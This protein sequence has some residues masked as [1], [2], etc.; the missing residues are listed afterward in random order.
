MRVC[1]TNY[2]YHSLLNPEFDKVEPM[3]KDGLQPLSKFPNSDRWQQIEKHMPGFYKNLYEN[4]AQPII[5]KPYNNSG[6][7][8]TPIDFQKLPALLLYNKTRIKIPMTRLD[9]AYCVITYI[10]N[11]ERLSFALTPENLEQT[12]VIWNADLV[13][14]WF[15][16]DKTKMF[17]YVPQ[18][19]IYQPQGIPI[20]FDDI[21]EFSK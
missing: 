20:E 2:V 16:K 3:L 5:K 11:D 6:I 17:Y 8:V 21:E 14:T 4:V 9:P 15:A 1:S 10:L 19:A 12:A 7:F 18:I 13:N